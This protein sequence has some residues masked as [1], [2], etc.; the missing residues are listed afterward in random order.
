MT[1]HEKHPSWYKAL[2]AFEADVSLDDF[3]L[4]TVRIRDPNAASFNALVAFQEKHRTA[5]E[6]SQAM[7]I[8]TYFVSSTSSGIP[9]RDSDLNAWTQ[10]LCDTSA[11]V[12]TRLRLATTL[13]S[14]AEMGGN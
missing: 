12:I 4:G 2:S 9:A 6:K 3:G 13:M 1:E 14:D 10:W 11:K 7:Q 8:K 5:P